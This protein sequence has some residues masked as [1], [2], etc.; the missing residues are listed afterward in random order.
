[1]RL[2]ELIKNMKTFELARIL[3]EDKCVYC[4]EFYADDKTTKCDIRGCN[5]Y[6]RKYLEQ[7]IFIKYNYYVNIEYAMGDQPTW[8]LDK[9]N[10]VK[11]F[12]DDNFDTIKHIVSKKVIKVEKIYK[13]LG[14]CKEVKLNLQIQ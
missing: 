9:D 10:L 13:I 1:M 14:S 2:Y 8:V 3:Y 11:L 7:E 6:I 12:K 5:A 4:T